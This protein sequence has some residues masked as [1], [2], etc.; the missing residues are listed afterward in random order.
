MI[1]HWPLILLVLLVALVIFG[2]KRLPELGQSLG[3][4]INEFRHAS[5]SALG[6]PPLSPPQPGSQDGPPSPPPPVGAA[7]GPTDRAN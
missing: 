2:P 1:D 7:P 5:Q 3:R 6:D 4:A